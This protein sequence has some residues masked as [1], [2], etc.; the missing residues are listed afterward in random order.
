MLISWNVSL[1][2]LSVLVAMT[3]SFTALAHAERMRESSERAAMWW[4]ILG[5]ITLGAAIW[6]MHFIGMLALHLPIPLAYDTFLT[7]LS[8]VPAIGSALLGFW[9]LRDEQI[10]SLRLFISGLVMGAGI[11]LMHYTGM[12]AIKMSPPIGY[13]PMVVVL[14]VAIAVIASWG[15]LLMM[16][17]GN[18]IKLHSL[19]RSLLGATIMGL[20]ISGMHYSAMLGLDVAPGSMCLS[21]EFSIEPRLLA[22]LV[23][24]ISL[25]WF[26]GGILASM[27]D[28]RLARQNAHALTD[29]EEAHSELQQR[30]AQQAEEMTQSLRESEER[31][32]LTIDKAL[33][34]IITINVDGKIVGWNSEAEKMF[35][36]FAAET[37]GKELAEL[38]I[39]ERYRCR[40][41]EGMQRFLSSR[42]PTIL[43]TRVEVAAFRQGGEEFP[44]ELSIVTIPHGKELF[45]SAF[46]RDITQRKQNEQ[47]I[48]QLAFYDVLTNLPNRRLLTDRLQQA[49]SVSARNH[50]HGALLFLD[51]DHFKTLND[52]KGHEIGDLLLVEVARRL[53]SCL[54][55]GDTVARLGGDEFVLVLETLDLKADIAANQAEA[56]AEKI[57][58]A[59]NEPYQLKGRNHRTTPSIGIAMFKGHRDSL[60]EL[61]KYADIAM[62]Q[63]KT[64]GRNAIRFY[65]PKTQSEIE[66]RADMETE[67]R[68]ALEESQFQLHY[69]IQVDSRRRALGAEVL[70]RWVHPVRGLVSPMDFIP[71]AEETGLIVP[72]G[73]W[74]LE[75]ACQQ[76]RAWQDEPLMCDLTLAVNVSVKQFRQRDFVARVRQVLQDSGAKPGQLKLELTESMVQENVEAT[77]AKMGELKQLGVNFSMDDFGTGY[78]SLQYLKQLP[79]DQIKI[80]QS[81]V[82][83]LATDTNDAAIVK[84]IIA[85]GAALG[86]DVIAEGVETEAQCEFL[87]A[88]GCH[89]FQGYLFGKPVPLEQFS[90]LFSAGA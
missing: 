56:V 13:S 62:Y 76:L 69:Q 34:A 9:V 12:E 38:I 86:L 39:P 10:G 36:Y 72:I 85:M 6:S 22:V 74:V 48:H 61:L 66:A 28:Q 67:L 64:A 19:L 84:T 68:L 14:S 42:V 75:T 23:A 58:A 1:V 15:A 87:V 50:H 24:L 81:F 71:L 44:I 21:T 89:A 82:R 49:L 18:R 47:K 33:D 7:L 63:A 54:R 70:L 5:S 43:G 17:R 52:T 73:L 25:F 51:L 45:F 65:D 46:L 26:G 88:N 4:M 3:G 57:Q 8:I 83:D 27:F 29:L 78:S 35:G 2:L 16:Y 79:L 55:D 11:S 53:S 60:D 41:R 32:R 40:H 80:D 90:A 20:A 30:A 31:F 59:L 77:I 37:M